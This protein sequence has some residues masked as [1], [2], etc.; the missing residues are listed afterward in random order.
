MTPHRLQWPP[1]V[2]NIFFHPA[3]FHLDSVF[4]SRLPVCLSAVFL[5]NCLITIIIIVIVNIPRL[6][7]LVKCFSKI[8]K[9]FARLFCQFT[10]SQGFKPCIKVMVNVWRPSGTEV[11][12]ALP[13]TEGDATCILRKRC[14]D[15]FSLKLSF[16]RPGALPVSF[17]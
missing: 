5:F 15:F 2:L 4:G 10:N 6:S 8:F 16:Y 17:R 3:L 7:S 13:G 9:N 12:P 14:C 11:F 1:A